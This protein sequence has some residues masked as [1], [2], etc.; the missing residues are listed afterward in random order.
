MTSKPARFDW[1]AIHRE[2]EGRLAHFGAT[3]ES[4]DEQVQALLRE[5]TLQLAAPPKTARARTDVSRAIVLC[6]GAERYAL[7]V[8]CAQEVAT[9]TRAAL[10]PEAGAATLGIV[11]WRGEFVTVINLAALL[12]L[13]LSADNAPRL[14]VVLRGEEPRL[15]L[16]VSGVE[17]IAELVLS[18]LQPVDQLR[19]QRPEFLKGA[20]GGSL[21][22]INEA[23]LLAAL[24]EEVQAA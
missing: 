20:T 7:A 16:A 13:A 23:R 22:V 10:L 17:H 14:I 18:D 19:S 21:V 2:L 5:R 24:R 11:S 6:L 15:A 4:D 9:L 1:R 8:E 12:G 3:I